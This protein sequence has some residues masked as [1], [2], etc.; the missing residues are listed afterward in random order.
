MEIL[1]LENIKCNEPKAGYGDLHATA[2][3]IYFVCFD[4]AD[5]WKE[6]LWVN[7]GLIGMWFI[8]RAAKKR[9]QEMEL[10]RKGHEGRFLDELAEEMNDSWF[11]PAEEMTE[12]KRIHLGTSVRIKDIDGRKFTCEVKKEQVKQLQDFARLHS[13]EVMKES[14]KSQI[15]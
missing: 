13:W 3:G 10:W 15:L 4:K 9:K 5:T 6:M 2:E 14:S 12:L 11:V 8:G 7:F 1:T